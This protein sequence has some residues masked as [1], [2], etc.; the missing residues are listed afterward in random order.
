LIVD[1]LDN[2]NLILSSRN[3]KKTKVTNSYGLNIYDLIYHEKLVLTKTAVEEITHLLDPNREKGV[4]VEVAA[5][6]VVETQAEATP[7]TKKEAK[8]KAEKA[9]VKTEETPL[10][11][12]TENTEEAADNE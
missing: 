11:T 3:V 4:E 8:P 2:A 9:E 10:A 7:K 12:E 1:S 5:Q 6:P